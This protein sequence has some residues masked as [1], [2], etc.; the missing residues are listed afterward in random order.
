MAKQRQPLLVQCKQQAD[1]LSLM[2]NYTPLV[3]SGKDNNKQK[4]LTLILSQ[5]KLAFTGRNMLMALKT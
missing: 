1:P 2:Q 4:H 5:C 3:I